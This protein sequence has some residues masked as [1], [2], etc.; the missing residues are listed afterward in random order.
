MS[1][2]GAA[3]TAARQI[4]FT[5]HAEAG[6]WWAESDDL[7][8]PCAISP[9]FTPITCWSGAADTLD[10]MQQLCREGV[11]FVTGRPHAE[12]TLMF[13]FADNEALD[14]GAE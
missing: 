12:F 2:M 1:E 7:S 3:S 5:L 4:T 14:G 6:G 10:E 11:E 13:L 8:T 9:H